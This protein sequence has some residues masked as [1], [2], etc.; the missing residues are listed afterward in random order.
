MAP[1]A[2]KTAA[3]RTSRRCPPTSGARRRRWDGSDDFTRPLGARSPTPPRE[4][5]RGS[6]RDVRPYRVP[7][8][9][10][11]CVRAAHRYC[12]IRPRRIPGRVA[13]RRSGMPRPG[14]GTRRTL[15]G[16]CVA[17]SRHGR[18]WA[19]I[20][21]VTPASVLVTAHRRDDGTLAPA[22]RFAG[23]AGAVVQNGPDVWRLSTHS[24]PARCVGGRPGWRTP[25][26]SD[27]TTGSRNRPAA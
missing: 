25:L 11:R 9:W 15:R 5:V 21:C 17:G 10:D 4:A 2:A 7:A 13:R 3:G 20:D 24:R 26:G 1:A 12:R 23:A 16:R 18:S 27:C 19:W 22:P 8:A 6:A 14:P